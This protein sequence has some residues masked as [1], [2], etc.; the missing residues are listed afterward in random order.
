MKFMQNGEPYVFEHQCSSTVKGELMTEQEKREFLVH[1]LLDIYKKCNMSA[2]R[3]EKPS[4]SFFDKI[5]G[6]TVPSYY[7]DIV[8]NNYH[9][10]KGQSA[11]YIV[12]PKGTSIGNIDMKQLP[13]YMRNSY[14]KI[15]WGFVF[16]LEDQT[17]EKYKK[18]CHLAAQYKSQTVSSI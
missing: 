11:Y 16:C 18:G 1:N 10:A 17:S 14:V 5:K 13:D 15:I 9:G 2:A 8:I 6:K 4:L 3:C 7:P 12:L